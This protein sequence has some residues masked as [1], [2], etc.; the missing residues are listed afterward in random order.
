MPARL[1]RV[2]GIS[3][4]EPDH[5]IITD[6]PNLYDIFETVY[7][8]TADIWV[9]VFMVQVGQ[10]DI[11]Y[12]IDKEE[13]D[14]AFTALIDGRTTE[15]YF[16]RIISKAADRLSAALLSVLVMA[17]SARE[18]HNGARQ[19]SLTHTAQIER[20]IRLGVEHK[21]LQARNGCIESLNHVLSSGITVQYDRLEAVANG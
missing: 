18:A 2:F 10:Y 8:N 3:S 17:K 13:I 1:M 7:R 9:D 15:E 6:L 11:R 12:M 20:E 16:A 14:S 4:I 5:S 19:F 21:L